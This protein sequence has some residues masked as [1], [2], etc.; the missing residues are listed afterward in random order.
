MKTITRRSGVSVTVPDDVE[1]S[2]AKPAA[3]SPK[4]R[5][6]RALSASRGQPQ[7]SRVL[8][9]LKRAEFDVVDGVELARAKG[10]RGGAAT[11]RARSA[12]AG[13]RFRVDVPLAP[14]E[15][16]V[17]LVEQGGM[18]T[19]HLPSAS[20]ARSTRARTAA[21]TKAARSATFDVDLGQGS[22]TAAAAARSRSLLGSVFGDVR[23][24][25]LRYAANLVIKGGVKLLERNVRRGFVDMRASNPAAWPLLDSLEALDLPLDRPP[26]ILLFVHGTFSSTI[27]G[28]AAIA[29]AQAASFLAAARAQ[30]DAIVG[31]DHPTL[32]VDPRAN[33]ADLL[34]GLKRRKWKTPPQIDVVAHS[35]GG[36]VARSLVEDLL[37]GSGLALDVGKVVFVACTNEGTL[38]AEPDNWNELVNLYVNIT[39]AASSVVGGLL[40]QT[41]AAAIILDEAVQSLGS[42]VKLLAEVAVTDKAAP[43]IAAMEP[44]GGFVTNINRTQPGQPTPAQAHYFVVQSNFAAKL[45]G[46]GGPQEFPDR[47]KLWLADGA[48]DRLMK[49]ADNDL[50]VN[51][52]SMGAIDLPGGG[53]VRDTLDYKT[54]ADV[55]HTN[56]FTRPET[57]DALARW[58]ELAP[59]PGPRSALGKTRSGSA[60]PRK[61]PRSRKA[62]RHRAG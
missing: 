23:T 25:V 30:Y 15:G 26:R 46:N 41:R 32:S 57:A 9:A 35:R 2:K 8:A 10:K 59:G 18:Y 31:F 22:R 29:G 17:L 53:F 38:L 47:F 40:P 6:A 13:T 50:V 61:A 12:A 1:V 56:Y 58:L 20:S 55:Y 54:N 21:R 36:L 62:A 44:D 33:A 49:N 37:P 16:A 51:D 3:A 19:F 24:Y 5:G 28:F 43:G 14:K 52:S 60:R 27:G 42:F 11:A 48:I 7:T 39:A 34:A 4:A 45:L